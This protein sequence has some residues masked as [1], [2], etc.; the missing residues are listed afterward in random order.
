MDASALLQNIRL[1]PVVV[2]DDYSRAAQLADTLLQAGSGA[3]A[4]LS[5]EA[6]ALT[7]T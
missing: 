3:I 7:T 2:I 5:R 4:R 1:L 6:V